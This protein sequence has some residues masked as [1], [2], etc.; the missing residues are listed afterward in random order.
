MEAVCS[1]KTLIVLYKAAQRHVLEIRI[2]NLHTNLHFDSVMKEI[3]HC[4]QYGSKG[5][6]REICVLINP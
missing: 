1:H 4:E 6:P 2:L 5:C 3:M